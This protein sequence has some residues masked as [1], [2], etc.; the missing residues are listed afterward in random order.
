MSLYDLDVT[1]L[2][3]TGTTL[4]ALT[5]GRAALVVN[6]ASKCGLTPQYEALEK[7]YEKF[8]EMGRLVL[9]FPS[10]EFEEQEP[11]TNAEIYD[12]CVSKFGVKFPMFEKIVVKGQGQ[13]PLYSYLTKTIPE[14]QVVN[15]NSFEEKLKTY[16]I[17]RT[18]KN[19]I[20]WNFEKFLIDRKGEVIA[21]FGPDVTPDDPIITRAIETALAD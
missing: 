21:R 1:T 12:F 9:G 6:V 17:V 18:Q 14:A 3:G 20:L 11:G 15:G 5:G 13:H 2:Q 19:D 8:H 7:I 10:N 4:G 16:G